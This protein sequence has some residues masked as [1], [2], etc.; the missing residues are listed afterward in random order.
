MKRSVFFLVFVITSYSGIAQTNSSPEGIIDNFF[1]LY[2]KKSLSTALDT[3]FSYGD[4]YVTRALPYIKDTL[5]GT[6]KG[7]G[8][9]YCGNELIMKKNVSPSYCIYSYLVKY[10]AN[11]LRFTF[12]FYKPEEKWIMLSFFFDSNLLTETTD[13]TRL[14]PS[15]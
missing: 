10:P 3:I 11:P 4:K 8:N 14:Q 6:I 2:E 13:L 12:I 1:R 5:A 15:K 7:V 9:K